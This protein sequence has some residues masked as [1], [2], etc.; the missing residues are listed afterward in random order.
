[1]SSKGAQVAPSGDQ[2]APKRLQVEPNRRPRRPQEL[3]E[4]SPRAF[5]EDKR[6]YTEFAF[7][8]ARERGSEGMPNA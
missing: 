3:P 2:E 7:S 1:M 5:G 4:S 8:S 6:Q